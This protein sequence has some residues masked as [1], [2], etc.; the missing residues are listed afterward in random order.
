V[1]YERD[2]L[3]ALTPELL[4]LRNRTAAIGAQKYMKDISPFLGVKTPERRALVK[5]IARKLKPPSSDELAVTNM[6]PMI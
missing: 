3:S 2:F 4:A 6:L 1:S 5:K